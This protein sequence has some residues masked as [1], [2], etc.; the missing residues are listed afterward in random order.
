MCIGSGLPKPEAYPYSDSSTIGKEVNIFVK[1]YQSIVSRTI[2]VSGLAK[3]PPTSPNSHPSKYKYNCRMANFRIAF[4]PGS[5]IP[6]R[7][8]INHLMEFMSNLATTSGNTRNLNGITRGSAS[9]SATSG[10]QELNRKFTPSISS[11]KMFCLKSIN[12][13]IK[14]SKLWVLSSILTTAPSATTAPISSAS[15]Q[16][17]APQP[18]SKN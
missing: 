4:L 14:P 2:L 10:C 17:S 5:I 8:R 11:G 7:I 13:A 12:L 6:D 18:I 15:P 1:K 16:D 3:Y 9:T